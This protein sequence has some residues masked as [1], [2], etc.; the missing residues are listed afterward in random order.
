[1]KHRL[2]VRHSVRAVVSDLSIS[3]GEI[4]EGLTLNINIAYDHRVQHEFSPSSFG[5]VQGYW[6]E[7]YQIRDWS[8]YFSW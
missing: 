4:L 3:Y 6:K 2:T 5:Y 7:K 1:M 8:V